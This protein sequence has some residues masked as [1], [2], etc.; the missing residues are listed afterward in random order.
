MN[1]INKYLEKDGVFMWYDIY[2]KDHF[3][4][5]PNADSW[6][7][8]EKQMVELSSECGLKKTAS[9]PLFKLFLGKY[10]SLYQAKRFSPKMLTFLEKMIPGSPGNIMMIFEK[11]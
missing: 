11:I 2:S 5:K 9:Y 10:H 8:S 4:P 7:F 1:Q 6:G 3:N